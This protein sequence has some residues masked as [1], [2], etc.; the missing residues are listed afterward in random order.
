MSLM[1]LGFGAFFYYDGAIG[2]RKKN[3][4]YY[5]YAAKSQ[6]KDFFKLASIEKG[7]TGANEQTKL[8]PANNKETWLA[9]AKNYDVTLHAK[10][11]VNSKETII[12]DVNG[13]FPENYTFTQ[14][15][16]N[17]FVIEYDSM[18]KDP[19]Q[20]E[21]L[22]KKHAAQTGISES[23]GEHFKTLDVIQSQYKWAIGS[24]IFGLIALFFLIRTS[25]RQMKVDHEGYTAPDGTHI[26]FSS[27]SKIDK[28]KWQRK[29]LAYLF[30]KDSNGQEKK[31][32]V[33]GMV[34]GQFDKQNPNN[35]EALYQYIESRVAD[36]EIIDY[37][38]EENLEEK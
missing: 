37:A 11:D 31:A 27:V 29:G 14:K 35:A 20:I 4:N 9:F 3:V 7:N 5:Q 25:L 18:I 30:F 22:W 26:P 36:V 8:S 38:D 34:Y 1:L 21:A 16:P 10:R 23:A 6:V 15:I 24:G 2:Y 17:I 33:D 28:R 19:L 12:T 32:R 13:C